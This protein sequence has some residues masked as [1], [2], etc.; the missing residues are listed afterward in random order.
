[1]KKVEIIVEGSGAQVYA[2][3]IDEEAIKLLEKKR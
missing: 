1:M 3:E 2:Y